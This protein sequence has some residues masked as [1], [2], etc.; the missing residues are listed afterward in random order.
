MLPTDV[1]LEAC[2]PSGGKRDDG[3]VF[4]AQLAVLD[5]PFDLPVVHPSGAKARLV[6]QVEHSGML[7]SERTGGSERGKRVLK[8]RLAVLVRSG[9]QRQADV[10]P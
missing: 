1:R 5:G 9:A 4:E 8:N 6:G 3:T 7:V 2:Y 10:C